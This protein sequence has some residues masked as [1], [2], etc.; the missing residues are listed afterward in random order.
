MDLSKSTSMTNHDSVLFPEITDNFDF[1]RKHFNISENSMDPEI[2]S[3]NRELL[4]SEYNP[5]KVDLWT[6]TCPDAPNFDDLYGILQNIDDGFSNQK[7]RDPAADAAAEIIL[8]QIAAHALTAS[9]WPEPAVGRVDGGGAPPHRRSAAAGIVDSLL[10]DPRRC[11]RALASLQRR[12]AALSRPRDAP[13]TPPLTLP[14]EPPPPPQYFPP[15]AGGVGLGLAATA[16]LRQGWLQKLRS[17]RL[18]DSARRWRACWCIVLPGEL[19]TGPSP[20]VAA[21][22]SGSKRHSRSDEA[23]TP[24]LPP[25]IPFND[26]PLSACRRY[27]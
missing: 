2:Y 25:A 18:D 14:P 1:S 13:P 24:V 22:G 21:P 15:N 26:R 11:D 9:G 20:A 23:R 3:E 12:L 10:L 19:R 8:R 27:G 7:D 4:T 5:T 16:P 17:G 6:S